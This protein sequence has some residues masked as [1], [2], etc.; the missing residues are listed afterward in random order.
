[1]STVVIGV[2]PGDSMG[3]AA[4]QDGKLI[5]AFQGKPEDGMIMIEVLVE[6]FTPE[7]GHHLVIAC[8]RFVEL[9]RTAKTHQPVAQQVCGVVQ[10]IA[11]KH[12]VRLQWQGPADAWAVADNMLLRRLGLFRSRGD[13]DQSDANDVNMAIRHALLCV[14]RLYATTFDQMLA[15]AER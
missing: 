8:E 11:N 5:A 13:V 7:A 1:M 12:D 6:K 9:G 4:L 10:A 3:V 14:A 2:D 15:T